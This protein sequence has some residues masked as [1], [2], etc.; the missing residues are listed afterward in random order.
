VAV[1]GSLA[2]AALAGCRGQ[3]AQSGRDWERFPAVVS[4]TGASV[5]YAL[6][7]LHGD[8]GAATRTLVAAGLITAGA[9]HAWTGGDAVLVVTGDVID[10][11]ASGTPLI[12]L[13]TRLEGQ[14][15][16]AGGQVIVTL[17]NHEAEFV[18]DPQ[19]DKVD[20][21]RAELTT[22]GLD[23][24]DVAAGKSA[25]GAWLL[26]RP[27]AAV[28]DGWFFSHAGNSRGLSLAAL[29]EKFRALF[30]ASAAVDPTPNFGAKL[31]ADGNSVL[32]AEI[33]WTGGSSP[34]SAI[35]ANLAALPATHLVFGHD[36]AAIDFP[37]DPAGARERGRI[38]ARYDGR[39]FLIDVGM[40]YAVGD[41]MG[42]LLRIDRGDPDVAT[43]L[44][45]DGT[46]EQLLP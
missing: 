25:Y 28:V 46:S 21:F 3:D 35:D 33:W 39:I 10:K 32:E 2:L 14:A 44:Y 16:A 36:P 22:L 34:T 30:P 24:G 29:D 40:S 31:L 6:G 11:G 19:S 17:G 9:E 20:E 4:V 5:I 15:R 27:V 8:P 38:A 26:N 42:G 18:A 37:D 7:D 43:A 41:S 45:A 1:A 13:L 12:D 23:P